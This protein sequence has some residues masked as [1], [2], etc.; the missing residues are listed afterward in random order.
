ML[1]SA[2]SRRD[3]LVLAAGM[4]AWRP[5][6][7]WAGKDFWDAK[8]PD[9]WSSDEVR[10]LLTKS[11]WAREITGER[12]AARKKTQPGLPPPDHY[13]PGPAAHCDPQ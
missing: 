5:S 10:K 2:L 12:T 7:A 6:R 11:P 1:D 4:L 8:D 3:W 9:S 13:R